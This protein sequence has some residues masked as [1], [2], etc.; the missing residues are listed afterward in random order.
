MGVITMKELLTENTDEI[1]ALGVVGITLG[2]M[3]YQSII[4]GTVTFPT[5]PLM[6][7]LGYYF[8]KKVA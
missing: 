2:V 6:I 8:G 1:L 4:D 3:A 7:I 5:E